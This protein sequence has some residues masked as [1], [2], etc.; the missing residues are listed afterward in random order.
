MSKTVKVLRLFETYNPDDT[1]ERRLDEQVPASIIAVNMDGR[2]VAMSYLAAPSVASLMMVFEPF[3]NV[4][5][6]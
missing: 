2:S 6:E 5:K 1:P 4:R 3:D